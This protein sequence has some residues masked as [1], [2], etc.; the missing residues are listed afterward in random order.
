MSSVKKGYFSLRAESEAVNQIFAQFFFTYFV[1]ENGS[2]L[3]LV[4]SEDLLSVRKFLKRYC[5]I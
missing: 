2:V 3:P 5:A 1:R 4:A